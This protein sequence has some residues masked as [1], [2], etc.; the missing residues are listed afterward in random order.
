MVVEGSGVDVSYAVGVIVTSDEGVKDSL[1]FCVM[2]TDGKGVKV[3]E[4]SSV[5][6]TFVV[7]L[8]M[9][10]VCFGLVAVVSIG[11][12]LLIGCGVVS[13]DTVFV[14]VACLNGS[15]V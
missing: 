8:V 14:A 15:E 3:L 11:Y 13:G 2:V 5:G 9:V 1:L 4:N 6:L 10:L 12:G 7:V